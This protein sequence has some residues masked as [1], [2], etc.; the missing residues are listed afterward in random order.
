MLWY[1]E[2]HGIRIT[3]PRIGYRAEFYFFQ[4]GSKY[5]PVARF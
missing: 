4:G 2:I 1:C 5:S 3:A